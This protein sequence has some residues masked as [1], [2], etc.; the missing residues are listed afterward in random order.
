MPKK[1]ISGEDLRRHTKDI[2]RFF[3]KIDATKDCWNWTGIKNT[4]GYAEFKLNNKYVKAYRYS[5]E[6][7]I[8]DIPQGLTIDHLCR[9][10]AC[11]NP[12]HLDPV[13]LRENILRGNNPT[14]INFRKKVCLRGHVLKGKNIK[15]KI[16][17]NGSKYRLCQPCSRILKK[18][19]REREKVKKH[20]PAYLDF[21][22]KLKS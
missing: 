4:R 15:I 20:V 16:A 12:K 9:N 21:F 14:A 22:K 13:S 17:E 1:Y 6:L 18:N 7:L 2:L 11:V 10:R 5:Y 8:G 19:Y 3:S